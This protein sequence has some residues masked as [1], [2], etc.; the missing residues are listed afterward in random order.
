MATRRYVDSAAAAN[1]SRLPPLT[2]PRCLSATILVHQ[3]GYWTVH[4]VSVEV[5]G[6]VVQANEK[7]LNAGDCIVDSG[8][9]YVIWPKHVF[10]GMFN[11]MQEDCAGN[12][13]LGVCNETFAGSMFGGTYDCW[14][15]TDAQ[16]ARYPTLSINLGSDDAPQRIDF[17]PQDYFMKT[18]DGWTC[19]AMAP[20]TRADGVILGDTLMQQYQVIFDQEAGADKARIGFLPTS[21]CAATASPVQRAAHP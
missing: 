4:A 15:L 14:Q 8:T 1:R 16:A 11:L 21:S 10:R 12:D 3:D 17:G 6:H 7:V 19:L 18:D 9:T 20:D 13:L 5:D 2:P